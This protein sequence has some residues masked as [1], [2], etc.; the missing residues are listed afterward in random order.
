[1]R[2]LLA[3]YGNEVWASVASNWSFGGRRVRQFGHRP[4]DDTLSYFLG[5][6]CERRCSWPISLSSNYLASRR[7]C[8]CLIKMLK[9]APG[10]EG[11]GVVPPSARGRR[12]RRG[13]RG[14]W[15]TN[16]RGHYRRWPIWWFE[17]DVTNGTRAQRTSHLLC[18]VAARVGCCSYAN[19]VGRP[20][21][22][23]SNVALCPLWDAIS[24]RLW[25]NE[26]TLK[27]RAQWRSVR[28]C[29]ERGKWTRL[30]FW[31][32]NWR[33]SRWTDGCGLFKWPTR[34]LAVESETAKNRTEE[35]FARVGKFI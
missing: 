23:H 6:R 22:I 18:Q 13:R 32:K 1:M 35:S 14:D 20:A 16:G 34:W 33:R 2:A 31:R 15:G 30:H 24:L 7:Q 5:C 28:V 9:L 29:C 10:R 3:N 19:G 12:G 21:L 11:A 8:T 17:S 26:L 4:V 27:L 25:I